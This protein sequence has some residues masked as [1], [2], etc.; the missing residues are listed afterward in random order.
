MFGVLT[1]EAGSRVQ[2]VL[3]HCDRNTDPEWGALTEV[4]HPTWCRNR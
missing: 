4:K 2:A 3:T 1:V